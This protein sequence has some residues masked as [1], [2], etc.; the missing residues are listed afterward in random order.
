MRKL[1]LNSTRTPRI[2]SN[3]IQPWDT[4]IHSRLR[5]AIPY[6]RVEVSWLWR[7]YW[8]LLI[9]CVQWRV[10][11]DWRLNTYK[12]LQRKMTSNSL[13]IIRFCIFLLY[14]VFSSGIVDWKYQIV[15]LRPRGG[16][17]RFQTFLMT[18]F[19]LFYSQRAVHASD[20]LHKN[21]SELGINISCLCP[22]V[23]VISIEFCNLT[24]GSSQHAFSKQSVL[25]A[26]LELR[27][28]TS[29]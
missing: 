29:I 2:F 19:L 20:S 9:G 11:F 6:Y 7:W 17:L 13:Q 1:H 23:P 3:F 21:S 28:F 25:F 10:P 12:L 5:N 14:C 27:R 24:F 18:P 4:L 26:Y 15:N 8:Q 16:C 22:H